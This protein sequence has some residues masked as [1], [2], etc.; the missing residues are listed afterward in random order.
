MPKKL[1]CLTLLFCPVLFTPATLY[2]A[3]A[4]SQTVE[5]YSPTT[6]TVV[7]QANNPLKPDTVRSSQTSVG[8]GE[9]V[10]NID[11][12]E[13][14]IAG[15]LITINVSSNAEVLVWKMVGPGGKWN[16]SD[17]GKT[18][19]FSSRLAGTYSF[20][21][22]ASKTQGE[23][24]PP[25][26]TM[27]EHIVKLTGGVNPNP[28]PQPNPNPLPGPGPAPLPPGRYGLAEFTRIQILSNIPLDKRSTCAAL[29]GNFAT[30]ASQIGAGTIKT[31]TEANTSLVTKNRA[32]AGEVDKA[33]WTNGVISPVAT[34]LNELTKAGSIKVLD[35]LKT[36]FEEIGAGFT[37]GS[38]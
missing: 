38:N 19:N 31:M 17:A 23:A 28:G 21:G 26:L 8:A 20:I 35:D 1:L 27:K 34:R 3:R 25:L 6:A 32:T 11:G 12:P 36:A 4:S 10:F 13:E 33:L 5:P 37:A 29:G 22:A 30:V 15:D 9:M 2:P 16:A 7:T 24:K 14:G 18:I